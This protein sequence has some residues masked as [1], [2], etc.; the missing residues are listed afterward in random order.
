MEKGH[1]L[2]PRQVCRVPDNIYL[3][4]CS[5]KDLESEPGL[6]ITNKEVRKLWVSKNSPFYLALKKEIHTH[7]FRLYMP[8]P[9]L[10]ISRVFRCFLATEG[11][12]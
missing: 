1:L 3:A 8:V 4:L 5:T 2:D 11:V 6:L 10:R 7:R 12:F 9:V